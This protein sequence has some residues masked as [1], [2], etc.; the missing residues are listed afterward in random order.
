MKICFINTR[1]WESD[2]GGKDSIIL[3][4]SFSALVFLHE[5][6]A[7]LDTKNQSYSS[8]MHEDDA[9]LELRRCGQESKEHF[10]VNMELNLERV[11]DTNFMDS[12]DI[13]DT[14]VVKT[15]EGKMSNAAPQMLNIAHKK[16]KILQ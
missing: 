11:C 14:N 6:D 4:S 3:F 7:T 9:T 13:L 16:T 10:Y 5:A 15:N 2:E 12:S 8:A 1:K